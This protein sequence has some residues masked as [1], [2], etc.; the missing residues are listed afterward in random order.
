MG[1]FRGLAIFLHFSKM[2]S[3]RY[4][5]ILDG[6]TTD[7][8]YFDENFHYYLELQYYG[9]VNTFVRAGKIRVKSMK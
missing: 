9:L 3:S 1:K 2:N 6:I 4:I 5:A 7:G 8:H